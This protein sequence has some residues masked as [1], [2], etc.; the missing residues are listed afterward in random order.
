MLERKIGLAG[1][2]VPQLDGEIA[3][4]R[5][6]DIVGGGVEE[7][8]TNF[9][10]SMLEPWQISEQKKARSLPRMARQFTD[11]LNVDDFVAVRVEG[12]VLRYLPNEN[13]PVVRGRG[14]YLVVERV[15]IPVSD[16]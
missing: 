15:P 7:D 3:R 8:L 10:R 6:E 16:W 11:G 14:N 12:E 4:C 13:L 9:S 5:G 1:T 2:D